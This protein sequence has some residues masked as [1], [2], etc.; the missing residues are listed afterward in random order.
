MIY[1]TIAVSS[2]QRT[3]KPSLENP[4]VCVI[5]NSKPVFYT[6]SPLRLEQ[7]LRA[8]EELKQKK[9]GGE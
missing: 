8:E 7:L 4:V 1:P 5:K 2:L 9:E 6:V 3:N